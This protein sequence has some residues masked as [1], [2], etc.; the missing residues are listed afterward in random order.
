[1]KN[2]YEQQRRQEESILKDL[3]VIFSI[4]LLFG[5]FISKS[6][7]AIPT[8]GLQLHITFDGCTVRDETGHV[9]NFEVHGN[10]QCVEGIRGNAFYFD[11]NDWIGADTFFPIADGTIILFVK[12]SQ[13]PAP[14][15][16]WC[17]IDSKTNFRSVFLATFP[18]NHSQPIIRI[19]YPN[20][21]FSQDLTNRWLMLTIVYYNGN[22]TQ[23]KRI[24]YLN[25]QKIDEQTGRINEYSIPWY[26]DDRT[27]NLNIG[28]C[29]GYNEFLKNATIDEIIFYNRPL[30]QQ[31]I[32]QIYQEF[33]S[34]SIC[35][36]YDEGFE[37]GKEWC[38]Q[39]P[40]ECGIEISCSSQTSSE[41]AATFDMF[42]NTL[43]IPNFENQY[44]LE[45]GLINWDPVQLELKRYGPLNGR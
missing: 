28:I 38:R 44:W 23:G 26:A 29:D 11:G 36:S 21:E 31:E 37:A 25:G 5:I 2:L 33:A 7:W 15:E 35:G 6:L 24:A 43:R 20:T 9:S 4:L 1:M 27:Q 41:C 18:E 17:L 45:F 42:T 30:S 39:H 16:T 12:F 8:D 14:G 22:T 40:Q 3:K 10:P 32:Q 34:V 13:R 19:G